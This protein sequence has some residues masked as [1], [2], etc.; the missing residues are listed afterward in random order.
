M[1]D[2]H[3]RVFVE[4]GRVPGWDL[5]LGVAFDKARYDSR[6][7]RVVL[8]RLLV[9]WFEFTYKSSTELVAERLNAAMSRRKP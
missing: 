2:W 3:G 6:Y 7:Q 4:S 1:I 9:W 5:M 8:V